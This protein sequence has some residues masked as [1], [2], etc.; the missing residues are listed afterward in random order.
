[1]S[2]RAKSK[3]NAK[4]QP[5]VPKRWLRV[6]AVLFP[7]ALLAFLE[8]GLRVF[9]FGYETQFFKQ[10]TINGAEYWVGNNQ[11]GRRFFPKAL[12]RTPGSF[13]FP[14]KKAPGTK[15]LFVLGESAA[16]GEP[17]PAFGFSRM[18]ERMLEGAAPSNHFEV[19]NVAMT[20][21]NSHVILPI[22]RDCAEREGDLWIVYMGNNEAV[23]PF[24]AGTVF[25]AQTPPITAVRANLWFKTT[26]VGQLLDAAVQRW[27]GSKSDQ[28]WKGMEMMSHQ[29]VPGW[30]RRMT[31]LYANFERNLSD[32]LNAAKSAN[33]PVLLCTVAVNERDCPPFASVHGPGFSDDETWRTNYAATNLEA[34]ASCEKL[35]PHYAELQF[36]LGHF[37]QAVDEDALRFRTDSVENELIRKAAGRAQLLDVSKNFGAAGNEDFYEHVHFTPE[38][39]YRVAR[40]MAEA[41]GPLLGLKGTNWLSLD[42]CQR[43]LGLTDWNRSR[44]LRM[45]VDRMSLPPFVGTLD[46]TNRVAKMQREVDA[47]AAEFSPQSYVS[48]GEYVLGACAR[49]P[50]DWQMRLNAGSLLSIGQQLPR[51]SEQLREALRL[52]PHAADPYFMLAGVLTFQGKTAEAIDL[53]KQALRF[54]PASFEVLIRLGIIE[55]DAHEFPEAIAHFEGAIRSKP[56]SISAR[57]RLGA[58][59]LQTGEVG[60]AREQ[61]KE[62]LRQEPGNKDAQQ[63]LQRAGG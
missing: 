14:V 35:D 20:A 56:D 18:L 54:D 49:H 40:M 60:K 15:R 25:G 8:I 38:G 16:M 11:F 33:V 30:D 6:A 17:Q 13:A 39:N 32:I 37:Q 34:L 7:F 62:V 58:A 53:Y 43:E 10:A 5:A 3:R 12:V 52:A 51:A 2:K 36:R 61:F 27:R 44:A 19:V 29:R 31:N 28:Y 45:I 63:M 23:G 22:A 41:V 9:G 59:F 21:I 24:G 50:E 57:L 47:F 4:V 55:L 1:M 42:D 48:Q 26:K 46:Q